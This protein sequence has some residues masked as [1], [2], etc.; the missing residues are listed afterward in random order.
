MVINLEDIIYLSLQVAVT[1]LTPL[2]SKPND[3]ALLECQSLITKDV[4]RLNDSLTPMDPYALT[5]AEV[6]DFVCRLIAVGTHQQ[7]CLDRLEE[8]GSTVLDERRLKV[9]MSRKFTSNALAIL[10]N[11]NPVFDNFFLF[12]C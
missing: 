11:I 2:N 1:Q 3:S 10:R 8:N 4:S 9:H 12:S 6:E 5:D 7:A